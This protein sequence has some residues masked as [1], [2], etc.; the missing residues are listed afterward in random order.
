M[1]RERLQD[2]ESLRVGMDDHLRLGL[3][4]GHRRGVI[5]RLAR[6]EARLG[7]VLATRGCKT[8]GLARGKRY[9]V[10]HRVEREPA[11]ERHCGHDGGRGE[12]VHREPVAVVAR[13]E[14][15][16]EGC[17]D[18]CNAL[19]MRFVDVCIGLLTLTILFTLLLVALPLNEGS[20]LGSKKEDVPYL[21]YTRSTSVSKNGCSDILKLT[22]NLITLDSR[23]DLLGT[24]SAQERN[25]GLE[26]CLLCLPGE[27]CDA[28]HVLVGTVCAG[29]DE[30]S[31]ELVLPPLVLHKRAELRKWGS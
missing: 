1:A 20:D 26:P 18:R 6:G 27:I 9:R 8:E 11:G 16:V 13:L 15:T 30:G 10:C 28:R 23:A 4:G 7:Q 14:V 31:R 24:W 12:E 2:L 22:R 29:T 17:Q 19:S 21:A 5:P 3:R 25:L